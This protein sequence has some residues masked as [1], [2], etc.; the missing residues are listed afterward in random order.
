MKTLHRQN[1]L[2]PMEEEEERF[3]RLAKVFSSAGFASEFRWVSD[4]NSQIFLLF[5]PH[6]NQVLNT[7]GLLL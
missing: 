2:P 7:A 5:S 1:L 6:I 4:Q 3:R